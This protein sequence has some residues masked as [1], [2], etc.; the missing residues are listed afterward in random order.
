M[1]F[2]LFFDLEKEPR[3]KLPTGILIMQNKYI[4]DSS[5]AFILLGTANACRDIIDIFVKEIPIPIHNTA[6]IL[7]YKFCVTGK[8]MTLNPIIIKEIIIRLT[9]L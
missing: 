6:V 9:L 8:T 4:I 3:I 1:V 7:I 2:K 5:L